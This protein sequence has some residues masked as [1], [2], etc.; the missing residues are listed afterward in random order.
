MFIYFAPQRGWSLNVSKAN[1]GGEGGNQYGHEKTTVGKI[2]SS[3]PT[4]I[5]I[6]KFITLN[7]N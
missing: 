2:G 1:H 3:F 4:V 6:L 5:Y 7:I